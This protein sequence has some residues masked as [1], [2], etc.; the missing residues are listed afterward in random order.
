MR[1]RIQDTDWVLV[2][3]LLINSRESKIVIIMIWHSCDL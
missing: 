1:R 3:S 2:D